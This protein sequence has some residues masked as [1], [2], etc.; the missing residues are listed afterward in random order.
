MI[1][2]GFS[3]LLRS[4]HVLGGLIA[5]AFVV[6]PITPGGAAEFGAGIARYKSFLGE[7]VARSGDAAAA[8]HDR[9]AAGDLA[10][11]QHAWLEAR[12]GWEA[13]EVVAD[14]F[15]PELDAAIDAWPDAKHGFH[16]IEAKLFGAHSTDVLAESEALLANLRT[17]QQ[18]LDATDLT[19][20]GLLNGATKLAFEIGENKSD[21]GES[22][23]SGNSLAEIGDNLAGID[24]A[25][26]QIFAAPLAA[27]DATL[28]RKV[29]ATIDEL[30]AVAA[31]DDLVKLD[32]M[33]LRRLSEELAV[34]LQAAG[35]AIGL[36]KPV[37]EN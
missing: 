15:F 16:A 31:V 3:V 10:G 23:F 37:L 13:A 33:R 26:R 14:E 12:G 6:M 27:E 11:A 19:A 20:Q 7:Q 30:H 36:Q 24:A 8:L 18:K 28:D 9:I 29:R 34:A 4:Q 5:V 35:P 21:G 2:M 22:P 25:Y 32:Q 17:F 1:V